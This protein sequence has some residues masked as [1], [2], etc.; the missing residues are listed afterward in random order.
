MI[1]RFTIKSSRIYASIRE[2]VSKDMSDKMMGNSY[3]KGHKHSEETIEKLKK[4][5][6]GR[7]PNLGKFHSEETRK[8]MSLSRK[9]SGNSNY[10]GAIYATNIMTNKVLIFKDLAEALEY[11][12]KSS[13]ISS[14]INGRRK[15]YKGHIFKRSVQTL[16]S[17]VQYLKQHSTKEL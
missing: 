12:F 11:G 17:A 9:G 6:A 15:I 3:A 5:R 1:N 14:S 16:E 8:G 10:K 13:G 2:Q 4:T 7:T